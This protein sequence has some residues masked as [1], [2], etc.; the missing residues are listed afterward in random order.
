MGGLVER[1]QDAA[2]AADEGFDEFGLGRAEGRVEPGID[3]RRQAAI[4]PDEGGTG[5]VDHGVLLGLGEVAEP[6]SAKGGSGGATGT[7]A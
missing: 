3:R 2:G 6:G 1:P 5:G 4:G 7:L